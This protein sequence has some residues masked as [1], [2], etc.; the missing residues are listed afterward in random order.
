MG[1]I[2]LSKYI[3]L[4][5]DF[6]FKKIFGNKQLLIPFLNAVL[7]K[8]KKVIKDVRYINKEMTGE[9]SDDRTI[10]YDIFCKVNGYDDFIIE[11]QHSIQDTFRERALFYMSKSIVQQARSQKKWKYKIYPT[12]GIFI[13]NFHIK[14]DRDKNGNVVTEAPSGPVA[15]YVISNEDNKADILTDKFKMIFI[16]LT[17]FTKDNEDDLDGNLEKWIFNIKNMGKL[18]TAPKMAKEKP[19][20]L[21]FKE[22][23]VAAMSPQTRRKYEASLLH[24]WDM[25]SVQETQRNARKRNREEGREEGR[26]EERIKNA[27]AILQSGA[28]GI[29]QVSQ[30]LNLTEDEVNKIMELECEPQK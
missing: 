24:Y 12:Y 15:R 1:E 2:V 8:E 10:F 26:A 4:L 18:K 6:G 17:A 16:D 14:R 27:I 5:T 20:C 7:D 23:E 3:D 13:T 30:I 25:L 11:M 28:M 29:E 19:F 22:S 9:Y 21:L